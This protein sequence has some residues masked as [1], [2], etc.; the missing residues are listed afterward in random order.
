MV[1]SVT[2]HLES[3]PIELGILKQHRVKNVSFKRF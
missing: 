1:V 3:R 2:I